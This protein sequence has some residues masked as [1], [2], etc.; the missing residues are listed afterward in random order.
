MKYDSCIA[1]FFC[2]TKPGRVAGPA[3]H[4]KLPDFVGLDVPWV[5]QQH[6]VINHDQQKSVGVHVIQISWGFCACRVGG[7]QHGSLADAERS[8][9]RFQQQFLCQFPCLHSR[10]LS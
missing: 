1:M 5:A 3:R 2:N 9:E 7:V 6:N 4:K 10:L 8:R